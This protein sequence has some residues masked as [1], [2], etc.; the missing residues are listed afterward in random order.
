MSRKRALSTCTSHI[1]AVTLHFVPCVYICHQPFKV[2]P[3]DTVMSIN[4][5]V[6]TP[7]LNPLI[8]TLRNHDRKSAVKRLKRKLGPSESS[9]LR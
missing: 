9:K 3:M 2:L 8:Y 6:V 4:N 7:M 5:T 1:L